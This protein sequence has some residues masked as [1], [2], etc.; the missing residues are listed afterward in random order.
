[1]LRALLFLLL[2]S[3]AA[4]AKFVVDFTPYAV[5]LTPRKKVVKQQPVREVIISQTQ[6]C[7]SCVA[8]PQQ[9]PSRITWTLPS[10]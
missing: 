8:A 7:R 3:A 2:L 6:E 4:E 1:M 9:L 5:S 10:R